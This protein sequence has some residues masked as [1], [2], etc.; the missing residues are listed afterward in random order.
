MGR[1]RMLA[2]AAVLGLVV[3]AFA[4][5]KAA[6]HVDT[7][8]GCTATGTFREGGQVVDAESVGD[9]VVEIPRSDTVDWT[10]SVAAP[11][12]AYS[13][14][15]SVDL[16]PPFGEVAI[17]SWGGTSQNPS[18]SGAKEYDLPSLVPAGVEFQVVGSHDD[19][20]GSCSGFV[21]LEIEGG[22]FD[23]LLAP[24]SLV[25][26]AASGAGLFALIRS[27]FKPGS[28]KVV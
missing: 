13:G 23:S 20:N 15:I 7:T 16:P 26:T 17:D 14:S 25:G 2:P 27:M 5:G 24:V 22:P 19:E 4:G 12:G 18:N 1:A 8:N 11:P 9:D 21:N 3:I 6:A 10:G 28:K